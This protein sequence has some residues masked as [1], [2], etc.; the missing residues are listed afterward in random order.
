MNSINRR[1]TQANLLVRT[2]RTLNSKKYLQLRR[3]SDFF[4]NQVLV[5]W[6]AVRNSGRE[7]RNTADGVTRFLKCIHPQM[8]STIQKILSLTAMP[9]NPPPA[10]RGQYFTTF[11]RKGS[12]YAWSAPRTSVTN[13]ILSPAWLSADRAN[14]SAVAFFDLG[15]LTGQWGELGPSRTMGSNPGCSSPQYMTGSR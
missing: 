15:S 8:S 3:K 10:G 1:I 5:S 9:V 13:S 11:Y 14:D 2:V 12:H 6:I 7:C 4:P